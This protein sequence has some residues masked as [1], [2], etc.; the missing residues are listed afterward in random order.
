MNDNEYSQ[1]L[2]WRANF[3]PVVIFKAMHIVGDAGNTIKSTMLTGYRI[4]SR[5]NDIVSSDAHISCT[6]YSAVLPDKFVFKIQEHKGIVYDNVI[7]EIAG[8]LKQ[9]FL[10][11]NH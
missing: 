5:S 11:L 6:F 8:S 4:Y 10:L 7:D 1:D 3:I 9:I 2:Y